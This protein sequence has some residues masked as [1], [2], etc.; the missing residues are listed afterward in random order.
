[1]H[2]LQP[3]SVNLVGIFRPSHSNLLQYR[4]WE[5]PLKICSQVWSSLHFSY[6]E[7]DHSTDCGQWG[8]H[9]RALPRL[10][11][12]CLHSLHTWLPIH[13]PGSEVSTAACNLHYLFT[14]RIWTE[15]YF[16]SVRTKKYY[17]GEERVVFAFSYSPC[18]W[19]RN[20]HT[21]AMAKL[22]TWSLDL[23]RG[24]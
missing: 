19:G 18:W 8:L 20:S 6:Q 3:V 12:N 11:S 21:R 16:F 5:T 24:Q 1:M 17:V 10:S 22:N 14:F 4:K 2:I 15:D 9:T 23:D 7:G 13:A